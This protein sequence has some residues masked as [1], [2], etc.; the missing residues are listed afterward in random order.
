MAEK[1][2]DRRAL[3]TQ[4]QLKIALADMLT[5]KELRH[6]TVQEVA[7]L[8]DVHR[9]TFYKHYYDIYDL[10]DQ[11]K[12][13][14]LAEIGLRT[15]KF[16]EE[17]AKEFGE[18]LIAYIQDNPSIFKMMFSPYNTAELKHSF[19]TMIEGIFRLVQSEKNLVALDDS[20]LDYISAYWS[21]G[22]IAVIEKWVESDFA[23]S[24]EF[25]LQLLIDLDAHMKAYIDK[26]FSL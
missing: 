22:C 4:K 1:R 5:K 9:V 11:L 17:P 24:K 10:Y 26:N 13:E 8:A 7:D 15:L 3:K 21:S 20:R 16:H 18:E 6:I 12:Q 19:T 25:I 14:A 23:H 2:T